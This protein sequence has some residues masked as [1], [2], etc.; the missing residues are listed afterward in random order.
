MMVNP[1]TGSFAQGDTVNCQ[2]PIYSA[3][4][5]P[6]VLTAPTG[7]YAIA[8]SAVA[9]SARLAKTGVFTKDS[10]SGLWTMTVTLTDADTSSLPAGVLYQQASVQDSDG[11]NELV[12]GAPLRIIP[13]LSAA[14]IAAAL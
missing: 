6:A 1:T 5:T 3:G 8:D 14:I 9:S 7:I 2:F 12:F 11:S 13:A 10:T 4:T